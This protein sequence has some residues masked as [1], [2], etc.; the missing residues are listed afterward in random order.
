MVFG[1]AHDCHAPA[2]RF[3][4]VALGNAF[5]G[6]VGALSLELGTDFSNDG[7]DV[8]LGKD[9]DCVYIGE[10][11]EY[12]RAFLGWHQGTP[13][14]FQSAH[15]IVGV[16]GHDELPA[17]LA[18]GAQVTHMSDMQKIEASVS[19][20]N[21]RAIATPFGDTFLELIARK[22]LLLGGGAQC[23]RVTGAV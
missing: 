23:G 21:A 1:I 12:F 3:Y 11:R 15:R 2:T 4:Y 13:G 10:G 17:Q 6:I 14:A 19:E 20:R 7:A 8:F 16:D 22:N 5:D 9:H 18:R